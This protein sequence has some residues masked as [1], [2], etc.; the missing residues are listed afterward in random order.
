MTLD[1]VLP[2]HSNTSQ[3]ALFSWKISFFMVTSEPWIARLCRPKWRE[4]RIRLSS[5]RRNRC[6]GKG[7]V[8]NADGDPRRR[9]DV[10]SSRV[11]PILGISD[12]SCPR[13]SRASTSY[14]PRNMKDVDGRDEPGH[15][16]VDGSQPM[17]VG[18]SWPT[19]VSAKVSRSGEP[20]RRAI[21]YPRR[22]SYFA[23]LPAITWDRSPW[24]SHA[25]RASARP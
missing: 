10:A 21:C 25:P 19:N 8:H 11:I 3:R 12:S 5:H 4:E 7:H 2:I 15:D 9:C 16:N 22:R 13:L 24:R 1:W 14:K 23:P 17:I 6:P 18:I 20:A